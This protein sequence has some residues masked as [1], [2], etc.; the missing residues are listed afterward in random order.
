MDIYL[1]GRGG[2]A[3]VILDILHQQGRRVSAIVDDTP[4]PEMQQFRGVPIRAAFDVLSMAHCDRSRW[5]VAIED[6]LLRQ[7]IVQKLS[8]LGHSFTTAIHPAASIALG[9]QIAPGT[10]VM[11]NAAINPDTQIGAHTIINL[12]AVIDHDC[13]IASYCHVGPGCTLGG[14]VRL[15][16]GVFLNVGTAVC[17]HVE[18]GEYT[19]CGAGSVVVQSLPE[20]CLADGRPATVTGQR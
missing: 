17:P 10:V 11:A 16:S 3:K 6:N 15:H 2:Y 12:G 13:T 9:V 19:I 18:V 7:Q 20:Q 1:Y 5:I 8:N 14:H 4:H